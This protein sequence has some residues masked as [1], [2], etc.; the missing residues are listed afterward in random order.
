MTPALKQKLDEIYDRYSEPQ[1]R[2]CFVE[3]SNDDLFLSVATTA[4]QS[5]YGRPLD[6]EKDIPTRIHF[7]WIGYLITV[8][9]EFYLAGEWR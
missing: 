8:G 4:Y 1:I 5:R 9:N 6:A 2:R 3:R 7:I